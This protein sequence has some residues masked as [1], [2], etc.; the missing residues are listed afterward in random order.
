MIAL[1]Y[2]TA[3]AGAAGSLAR[4]LPTDSSIVCRELNLDREVGERQ[5]IAASL[6]GL[7]HVADAPD[8]NR[9]GDPAARHD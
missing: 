7:A 9:A 1:A 2:P 6:V 5:G 3:A 4:R 8:P